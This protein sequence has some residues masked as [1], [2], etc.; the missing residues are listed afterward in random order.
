MANFI[1]SAGLDRFVADLDRV[2][3]RVMDL[4]MAAISREGARLA[5]MFA[6]HRTGH[7]AASI[8]ASTSKSRA[9]IRAGGTAAPY[10]AAINYGYAR[11]N[12][13]PRMFMQ[14]ADEVLRV[15]A[16]RELDGQIRR[17]LQSRGLA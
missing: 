13:A 3:L 17:I 1:G 5:A 6:P 9:S 10:A 8:I 16:P 15:E 12:I 14:R 11:R 2:A 7:L 4:D